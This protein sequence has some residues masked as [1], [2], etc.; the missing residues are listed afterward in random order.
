LRQLSSRAEITA[1]IMA[2]DDRAAEQEKAAELRRREEQAREAA[3]YAAHL[4]ELAAAGEAPW[5]RI[6]AMIETKKTSEYDHAVVLL[7][8]LR[9]LDERWLPAVEVQRKSAKLSSRL[10]G[11]VAR[12]GAALLASAGR[13][14][15]A[16]LGSPVQAGVHDC[17]V[18]PGG[19]RTLAVTSAVAGPALATARMQVP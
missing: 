14:Q 2:A 5:E 4:D 6:E 13:V 18:R 17:A 16:V 12:P 3:A 8:E 15:V 9:A 1:T 7:R 10:W 11:T 19:S